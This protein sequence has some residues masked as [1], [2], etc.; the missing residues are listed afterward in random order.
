MRWC[1]LLTDRTLSI[2]WTR[3]RFTGKK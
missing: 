3:S 2:L 1:L